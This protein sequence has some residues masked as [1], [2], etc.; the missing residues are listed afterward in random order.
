MELAAL[1]KDWREG[2]GGYLVIKVEEQLQFET[3][4]PFT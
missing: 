4:V 2:L 3:I 1:R